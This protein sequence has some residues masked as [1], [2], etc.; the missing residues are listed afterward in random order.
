MPGEVGHEALRD[1]EQPLRVGVAARL[2]VDLEAAGGADAADRR[3][4][5][6]EREALAQRAAADHDVAR[7]RLGGVRAALVPLLQR[8]EHG[9]R[10]GLVAAADQVEA[11]DA[12]R[13]LHALVGGDDGG[14]IRRHRPRALEGRAVRQLHDGE[15]VALVLGGHEAAG[16]AQ[17]EG[18][19]ERDEGHEGE[20]R[21]ERVA[22]GELDAGEEAP[23]D[24]GERAVERRE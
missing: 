20:Q 4:V 14:E 17:E 11:D 3:R 2:Q 12:E 19:G 7:D 6:G 18:R 21:G 5:E 15:D 9:S 8:H 16:D 22:Q 10:V 13:V 1:L 24:P 23:G